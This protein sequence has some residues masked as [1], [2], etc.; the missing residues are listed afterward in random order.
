VR[1]EIDRLVMA[2]RAEP[3]DRPWQLRRGPGGEV[4][5]KHGLADA[6]GADDVGRIGEEAQL[7]LAPRPW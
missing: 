3:E 2:Q 6:V 5:G 7:M 1:L 4:L